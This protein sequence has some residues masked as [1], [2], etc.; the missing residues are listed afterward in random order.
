MD[1]APATLP[2]PL[3]WL[4][5]IAAAASAVVSAGDGAAAAGWQTWQGP[6]EGHESP[7]G[8][9]VDEVAHE[10]ARRHPLRQPRLRRRARIPQGSVTVPLSP[11]VREKAE[12]RSRC[13]QPPDFVVVTS[14][15]PF[16]PQVAWVIA[17]QLFSN[18][19]LSSFRDALPM[20]KNLL[21]SHVCKVRLTEIFPF[22]LQP[23]RTDCFFFVV[24][25]LYF[26]PA[27]LVLRISLFR[28]FT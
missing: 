21:T 7:S 2:S 26:S 9:G 13:Q 8:P 23:Y 1:F 10:A 4:A 20:K 22:L 14:A 28:D 17:I 11:S 12:S 19:E 24:R 5:E 27:F 6:Q 25:I 16:L 18:G 3:H 15:L